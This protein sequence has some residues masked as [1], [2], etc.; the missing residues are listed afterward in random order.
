VPEA[1]K[2][3]NPAERPGVDRSPAEAEAGKKQAAT[4]ASGLTSAIRSRL[5]WLPEDATANH[6]KESMAA[7]GRSPAVT[8]AGG[9]SRREGVGS[10]IE[11]EAPR[12]AR[13]HQLTTTLVPIA[14]RGGPS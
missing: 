5:A 11:S 3:K 4:V 13:R 1:S 12:P 14:K 7:F 8:Y 10:R 2:P 6:F 9:R